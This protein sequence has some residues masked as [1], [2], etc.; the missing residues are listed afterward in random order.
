MIAKLFARVLIFL[1]MYLFI[2]A[3]I[4]TISYFSLSKKI[5]INLPG[6]KS[7]QKNLYWNIQ[8][9]FVDVWQNKS[10]CITYDK[11][12]IYVPKIGSCKYKNAEF[13]TI[14]NF[15]EKGRSMPNSI[16][17]KKKTILVTGDSHAMGWGVNDNETFSYFLQSS[18]ET[19]VYNLAVSSYGTTREVMRINKS[20]LLEGSDILIVQ[21]HENDIHENINFHNIDKKKI[22]EKFSMMSESKNANLTELLKFI[23]RT[24]KSSLRLIFTDITG[25]FV[26]TKDE[27]NFDQHYPILLKELKNIRNFDD[28]K[29]IVFFSNGP[30]AR[31]FNFP[32]GFDENNKNIY[33]ANIKLSKEDHFFFR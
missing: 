23:L 11:D 26:K 15:T 20:G 8:F 13:D 1:V 16:K 6:F 5:F 10:N 29:I 32:E 33:F 4:Y 28:K 14:L 2:C 18:L 19:Q 12:L 3:V 17:N 9:G 30:E 25:L 31:F 21:Y 27:L 24:Y 22:E 7:I